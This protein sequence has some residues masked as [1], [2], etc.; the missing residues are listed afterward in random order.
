LIEHNVARNCNGRARSYNAGIWPW[1]TDNSRFQ[2]NEASWTHT[3]LDGQGFDSDF[4]SRNTVFQYNYSHDNE[5]GF[6]LIC[7]PG[8]RDQRENLGNTG[9]IVRY[10]ISH[11]DRSRIFHLSAAEH[12]LVHDNAIYVGPGLDVQMLI[13]TDWDGWA[14]DA[15]FRANRFYVDGTARYGHQ[16]SRNPDGIYGMAPGWGPAQ[17]IVFVGNHYA[18]RHIDKPADVIGIEE[19]LAGAPSQDWTAPEFDPAAPVGFEDFLARHREW[20]IRL[21]ERHFGTP[22]KLDRQ[23]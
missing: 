14:V 9:T 2:L 20:M 1:S 8:K 6:M 10:N 15:L 4:N 18:G 19:P 23:Q 11:N 17:G 16:V 13:T 3:T 5:G 22:F 21:F 7:T 12:T